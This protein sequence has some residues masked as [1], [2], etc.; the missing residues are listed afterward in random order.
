MNNRLE[1]LN[2]RDFWDRLEFDASRLLGSSPEKVLRRFWIDGFIPESATNTQ[3]G[4]DVEGIVWVGV[5]GEQ[6]QQSFRFVASIPQKMLK[7]R[8][9]KFE[10]GSLTLDCD[11]SLLH[12]IISRQ[13]HCNT[14]AVGN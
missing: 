12:L 8:A 5:G 2:D 11:R 14:A 4:L 13:V 10:I 6:E 3:R 7:K 9:R 1:I